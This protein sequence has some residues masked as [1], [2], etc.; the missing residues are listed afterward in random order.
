[1]ML[2]YIS[3]HSAESHPIYRGLIIINVILHFKSYFMFLLLFLKKTGNIII[4]N[5]TIV[6]ICIECKI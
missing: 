1:M 4:K 2:L 6:N 5:I 3:N